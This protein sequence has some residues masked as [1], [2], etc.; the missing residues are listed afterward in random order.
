MTTSKKVYL[1]ISHLL[2][3]TKQQTMYFVNYFSIFYFNI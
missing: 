3:V 2:L 1:F